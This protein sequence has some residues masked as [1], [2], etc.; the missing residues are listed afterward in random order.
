MDESDF[1]ELAWKGMILFSL[2][3]TVLGSKIPS[4]YGRFSRGGWGFTLDPRFTW[5]MQ[6]SPSFLVPLFVAGYLGGDQLKRTNIALLSMFLL[7]YFQR[8]VASYNRVH[9]F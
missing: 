8:Y 7:H 2:F 6:E 3:A 1:L 5:L 4:P 9:A